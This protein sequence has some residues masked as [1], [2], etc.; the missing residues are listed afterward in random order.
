MLVIFLPLVVVINEKRLAGHFDLKPRG[1]QKYP[2]SHDQA[3]PCRHGFGRG[4]RIIDALRAI[5]QIE[6]QP[7][8]G[9]NF[10]R[11]LR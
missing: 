11:I 8:F 3:H 10:G 7:I 2:A 1:L 5:P 6:C 4:E 9:E